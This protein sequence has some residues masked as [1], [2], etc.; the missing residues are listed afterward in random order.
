M[1]TIYEAVVAILGTPPAGTEDELYFLCFVILVF[2]LMSFLSVL[3]SVIS[4]LSGV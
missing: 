2:V 1:T 4:K 3:F